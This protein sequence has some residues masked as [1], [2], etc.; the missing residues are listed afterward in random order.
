MLKENPTLRT[1]NRQKSYKGQDKEKETREV[2]LK[3]PSQ[4]SED[5]ESISIISA[6]MHSLKPRADMVAG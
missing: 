3:E 5:N 4:I 1:I 2:K 6:N